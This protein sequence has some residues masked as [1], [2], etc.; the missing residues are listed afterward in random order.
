M[1]EDNGANTGSIDSLKNYSISFETLDN[2]KSFALTFHKI[3]NRSRQG[4]GARISAVERAFDLFD[5]NTIKHLFRD[6][7][8]ELFFASNYYLYNDSQCDTVRFSDENNDSNEFNCK[9]VITNSKK[10]A[11]TF[12]QMKKRDDPNP[13]PVNLT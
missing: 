13:T 3:K 2:K 1:Y 8:L 7:L 4:G 10:V 5:E 11:L 12:I 9:F 6:Y